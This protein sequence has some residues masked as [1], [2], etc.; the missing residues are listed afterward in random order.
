MFKNKVIEKE[1]SKVLHHF[2]AVVRMQK[3]SWCMRHSALMLQFIKILAF[4]NFGEKFKHSKYLE[5]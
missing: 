2:D 3:L 1:K 4:L 5:C